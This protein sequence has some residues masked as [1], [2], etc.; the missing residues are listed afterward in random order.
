MIDFSEEEASEIK[1]KNWI[2]GI[3]FD[4]LGFT[5]DEMEYFLNSL[6]IKIDEKIFSVKNELDELLRIKSKCSRY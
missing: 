5:V 4:C 6:N 1:R 3:I 2:D